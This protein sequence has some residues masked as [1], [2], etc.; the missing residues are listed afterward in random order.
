MPLLEFMHGFANMILMINDMT[1]GMFVPA[2]VGLIGVIAL[3]S[4]ATAINN[5]VMQIGMGIRAASALVSGGFAAAQ[6]V[7]AGAT[8]TES[9]TATSAIAPN[10]MLGATFMSMLVP[11]LLLTPAIVGLGM[12]LLGLGL[13]I[14]APFLALAAIVTA[15]KD[16]FIA[17]LEAPKAI[18]AAITGLLAFAVAG[19]AAMVIMATGMVA[20]TMI[21]SGFA[22]T[23]LTVAPALMSFALSM[24]VAGAAMYL[25]GAGLKSMGEGLAAFNDVTPEALITAIVGLAA[26]G[27][28]LVAFMT[29]ASLPMLVVGIGLML[30]GAGLKSFAKGLKEFN[31]VGLEEM[32]MAGLALVGFGLLLIKASF[33]MGIA[34]LALGIPLMMIGAGLKSFAK[35]IKEFSKVGVDDMMTAA[36][37]LVGFGLL[38]IKASFPMG[39]AALLLAIPLMMISAAL[40]MFAENLIKFNKVGLQE[41]LTAG[42]ALLMFGILMIGV[43][44]PIAFA[45]AIIAV[46]LTLLGLALVSF[47]SG[48]QEFNDV[49]A[50]GILLAVSSLM[51][52]AIAM[53][54]LEPLLP[55]MIA[56]FL[57]LSVPMIMFGAGL[58]AIGIGLLLIGAGMSTFTGLTEVLSVISAIGLSGAAA[59][60]VLAV[61]I[62][63]IAMALAFIPESKSIAFGFAMEGYGAAIAAVAALSPDTVELSERVVAAAGEYAEIQAEMKMPDEDSFVQ[64][65][66]NVFGMGDK[67][68]DSGKNIILQLNGRELGRAVDV[69]LNKMHNLSID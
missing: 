6:G 56:G 42:A 48:L 29:V 3:L 57:L 44:S 41:I 35:G 67:K 40:G 36:I 34:A 54:V 11:V 19:S 5:A 22:P 69:Q 24:A 10:A 61:S 66:K 47:A 1:G 2:M 60:G 25:A 49:G 39:I 45:A 16:L 28:G 33:P 62:M 43:T 20:A 31:K 63:G 37:A 68:G 27:V 4:K 46:P 50:G 13:A 52:F 32:A 65:M 38:L 55:I 15:F 17:M 14:A 21:L 23:M 18:G 64:A 7:L 59:M 12:G 53:A 51:L 30:F 8:A 26:F 58:S 9:L